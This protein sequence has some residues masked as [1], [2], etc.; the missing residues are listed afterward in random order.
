MKNVACIILC[1]SLLIGCNQ[2]Q[3]TSD[4][5]LDNV[6]KVLEINPDSAQVLLDNISKKLKG[7]SFA[8]WCMLSGKIAD[9]TY[10]TLLPAE[11]FEKAYYWYSKYGT[12]TEQAQILIYMGRSYAEDGDY[13]KAMDIY[14]DVIDIARKNKLNNFSGYAYSYMG[15]L[16]QQ[17]TMAGK[18]INKYKIAARYFREAENAKS[19]ACALRDVGYGYACMDSIG[20]ALDVLYMADSVAANLDN[21]NVKAS[22][23]NILGNTYL[24]KNDYEKAMRYFSEALELGRN[25]LP[26][27]VAIIEMYIKLDSVSKAKE[28]L[29]KIPEDNPEY[30]YSIKK[31][32]YLIY[33]SEKNYKSALYN[34]EE[35]SNI[36]DSVLLT[37]NK[38]KIVNIET[39][40][41]NLRI[42][43]Q[44]KSLNIKQ[45][46]YII[47]V[48]VCIS[49]ILLGVLGYLL[50]RKSVEERIR[51]H[52]LELSNLKIDFLNLSI[53][54]EKKK[55]MLSS[56]AVKGDKYNQ[57][58]EEIADL[59]GRYK[60]L[61]AKLLS[62][63]PLYKKLLKLVNQNIPGNKTP[64][65]TEKQWHL[66]YNEIISIYPNFYNYISSLCPTLT[67][68][69][70]EYCSFCMY[71]FDTNAEAKLLNI[72][73]GSVRTKRLRLKQRLNI[74]LPN[75][76][77]LY[78]YL[79]EK[80]I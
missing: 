50:Y 78:K 54:L 58:K 46:N 21:K 72:S 11:Q 44:V 17:R 60:K 12:P 62:N 31:L 10:K 25:K 80:L 59:S 32:S 45:K 22:I 52:K 6:E 20:Y 23:D 36:V 51:K 77:T 53:E 26:N 1:V 27:F 35:C 55:N 38:S 64:L 75:Q 70:V 14:T 40:Y 67:V 65:I 68:Q 37:T 47:I 15:D 66:I 57:M 56:I 13:D 48:I 18:A 4:P 79:V 71:G 3:S 49:I 42:K 16:Y 2:R 7:K 24:I 19:Y 29:K 5:L 33:K 9:K 69:E 34:L 41:N 61:Q 63:A 28:L 30:T 73:L 74:T 43:E 8:R 39:R 76:T